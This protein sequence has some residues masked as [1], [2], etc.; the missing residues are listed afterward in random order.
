MAAASASSEGR[1]GTAAGASRRRTRR[2][3]GERIAS[4]TVTSSWSDPDGDT[5]DSSRRAAR[6]SSAASGLPPDRST[7]SSST[8]ADARWPSIDSI[9]RASSSR[10]SG[11]SSSAGTARGAPAMTDR[12]VH[13]GW[14]RVTSSGRC[15]MTRAR[16][17]FRAIRARNVA[18]A[19][20]AASAR[21]RSSRMSS[22][23][24]SSPSRP[25]I[26]RIPSSVRAWRRSGTVM[27]ARAG[28]RPSGASRPA[29]SGMRRTASS[30]AGPVT[31]PSASSSRSH[32]ALRSASSTGAYGVSGPREAEPRSTVIG[33]ASSPIRRSA[34]FKKRVTPIPAVPETRSVPARPSA[35]PPR[36]VARRVN[37]AS[38]PTNRALAMPA[39][40]S[41]ILGTCRLR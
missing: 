36:T 23:G 7:T 17:W 6:S 14:S 22:T 31:R 33:S 21:W 27:V 20:V 16:R 19:R 18:R 4:R 24:R 2:H 1:R 13:H 11:S 5:D 32:S 25:R 37:A 35:A 34:S 30:E 39:G 3:S 40:M 15:V 10:R 41:A 26:P 29:S 12:S 9:S 38:R 28:S 8:L